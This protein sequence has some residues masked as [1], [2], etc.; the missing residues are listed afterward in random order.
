MSVREASVSHSASGLS[1]TRGSYAAALHVENLRCFGDRQTLSLLDAQGTPARWTVILGENGVGKTT[2]LQALALSAGGGVRYGELMMLD[3]WDFEDGPGRPLA[4]FRK[5]DVLGSVIA[6][7]RTAGDSRTVEWKITD[8]DVLGDFPPLELKTVVCGYGAGRRL[9]AT[10][11]RRYKRSS[12]LKHA[13]LFVD[14]PLRNAEEWLLGEDYAAAKEGASSGPAR[15]KLERLKELLTRLL[16]EVEDMRVGE[17][18]RRWEP[19]VEFKTPYG[20]VPLNGL[21]LGYQSLIAWMV[22]LA[23]TMFET[24]EKHADPLAQPAVVLVDEIDLHLHP[25]WQ[26]DLMTF[27]TDRFPN[28]QF[29]VTAHSPLVVQAAGDANVVLL[30]REGD[31]IIIDNT[32][33]DV[34]N[35]RI[36]QILTS[37]LYGLPTARSPR[38][39]GLITER[40]EILTKPKLNVEDRKRLRVLESKIGTLP[41]GESPDEIR[42]MDLILRNAKT[43]ASRRA[44]KRK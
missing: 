29:I 25:K 20:W 28:T 14:A 10:R 7:W 44:R 35:W 36:D 30:K 21:S 40:R 22:D 33:Q 4:F 3:F 13:S 41:S 11:L 42:A 16:P 24:Y 6:E 37:D 23:A 39:D 8:E 1:A 38:L 34:T 17:P 12:R 32:P 27:L 5:R 9:G 43:T 2:L 31:Q 18:H 26:R 19:T 15:R